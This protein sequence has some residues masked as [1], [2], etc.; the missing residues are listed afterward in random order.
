MLSLSPRSR[1][2]F[3]LIELLVV[4]AI[5]AILIG[6]LLPAVQ[7]VREAAARMKCTNNLKQM[8][9]A[10]QNHHDT[11][12]YLPHGGTG[13]DRA[14][15]YSAPGTPYG[16]KDQGCGWGFHIL[17]F[18]EQDSL[19]KGGGTTTVDA[20]S[21]QVRGTPVKAFYCPSK[22]GSSPRVFSGGSWYGPGGTVNFAQSDYA[23]C[24]GTSNNGAISY[25]DCK[26]SGWPAPAPNTFT[27]AMDM[28]NLAAITDGTSNTMLIGEKR[29]NSAAL[30]GFQGDDN[31]GYTSGWDHDVIRET[32][33]LPLP[34][35]N[36]G[37]GNGCFGGPHSGGF[38]T[39]FCDG[40]V[41]LI[42]YSVDITTFNRLGQRNDGQPITGNY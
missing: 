28:L 17:P 6:L 37:D 35:T 20:A 4:I 7:K 21:T 41:K 22:A 34:D 23:G 9:L 10:V 12:G 1:R 3:T 33:R 8:G 5:I 31:E 32:D 14:P 11:T 29:L 19:Y 27:P 13:W 18:L 42:S 24:Q 25:H 39:V 36:T 15:A 26:W 16:L 2:G 40:S 30:G 38:V